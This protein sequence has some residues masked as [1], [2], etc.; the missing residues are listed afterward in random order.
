V[1]LS[2]GL[3]FMPQLVRRGFR[4]AYLAATMTQVT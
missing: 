2:A 3:H 1:Y 4:T